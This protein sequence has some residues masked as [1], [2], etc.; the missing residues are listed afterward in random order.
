MKWLLLNIIFCYSLSTFSQG[1]PQDK[2]L[3]YKDSN[4]I[5]PEDKI[6][7]S[8]VYFN[9]YQKQLGLSDNDS[10]ILNGVFRHKNNLTVERYQHFHN[11]IEV[12]GSEII[13]H[14][15]NNHIVKSISVL[16]PEVNI[17]VSRAIDNNIDEEYLRVYRWLLKLHHHL[18]ILLPRHRSEF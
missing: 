8:S 16:N 3:I 12:V 14:N 9:K 7:K 4:L 18:A 1:S 6:Y 17:D 5:I 10:L 2:I 15:Y 13:L 11:G